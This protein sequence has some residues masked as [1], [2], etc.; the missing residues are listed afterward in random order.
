MTIKTV[1]FSEEICIN[2]GNYETKKVVKS[3]DYAIIDGEIVLFRDIETKV[4]NRGGSCSNI[5]N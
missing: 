4:I 1:N 5:I 3:I 2:T